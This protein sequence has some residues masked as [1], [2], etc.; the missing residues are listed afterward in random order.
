[1]DSSVNRINSLERI[2]LLSASEEGRIPF[3]Q[4]QTGDVDGISK[5]LIL[6]EARGYLR[7][8]DGGKYYRCFRLSEQGMGLRDSLRSPQ[9]A[10]T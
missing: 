4:W 8:E 3:L 7:R 9:T 2:I 5:A 1:M 10:G 6:M